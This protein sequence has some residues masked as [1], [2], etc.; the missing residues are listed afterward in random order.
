MTQL[1]QIYGFRY[2]HTIPIL[3]LI[4]CIMRSSPMEV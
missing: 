4:I 2:H 1:G 3:V